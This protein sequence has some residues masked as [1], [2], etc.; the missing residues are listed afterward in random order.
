MIQNTE[1]L[2]NT[3]TISAYTDNAAVLEGYPVPRFS[4]TQHPTGSCHLYQSQVE[5]MPILI[6][7]QTHNHPTAVSPYPG[8]ATVSGAEIRDEGMVGRGLKHKAE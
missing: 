1:K 4:V 7:V 6:K 5:E 2:N 3:G 8:A